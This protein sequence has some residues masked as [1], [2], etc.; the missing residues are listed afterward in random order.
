[1]K[2]LIMS[3][4]CATAMVAVAENAKPAKTLAEHRA[5]MIAAAGGLVTI[6]DREPGVCFANGQAAV[7]VDVISAC[8][9]EIKDLFRVKVTVEDEKYSSIEVLAKIKPIS[10]HGAIVAISEM[11]AMPA[12]V[13]AP[14]A[15][16]AV[17]N[18]SALQKDNPNAEK[19]A[20]RVKKEMWRAFA[21][22]MGSG[23]SV[24]PGCVLK[25]ATTNRELDMVPGHTIGPDSVARIFAKIKHLNMPQG[26][27]CT[28]RQAVED[29]WAPAPTND[30]QKAIWEK[31]HAMPTE[32]I[33]IKPEEKKIEK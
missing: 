24:T 7:P 23:W 21:Q 5:A 32:P 8:A 2:K 10:K 22:V 17:I 4:V 33:K 13:V 6:P 30:V 15:N 11:P 1:M 12:I 20:L 14:D 25:P 31:V 28:Y 3:A 19:L 16:W 29:G 26:G 9:K 18:I 27:T